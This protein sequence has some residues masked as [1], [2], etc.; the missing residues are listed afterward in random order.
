[1]MDGRLATLKATLKI[2]GE[3]EAAWQT[4]SAKAKQQA[5]TMQASHTAMSSQNTGASAPDRMTQRMAM[6]Q[7]HLGNMET[8]NGALKDLYA[9]LTPEQKA[10]ADQSF[11]HMRMAFGGR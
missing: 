1:M 10:I 8:M 4:F 2:T 5:A 3:Q 11:G 7:Q 9:V 6:M